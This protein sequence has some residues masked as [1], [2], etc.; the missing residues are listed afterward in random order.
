[1]V[2]VH[3][4]RVDFPHILAYMGVEAR[5]IQYIRKFALFYYNSCVKSKN[6]KNIMRKSTMQKIKDILD[7]PGTLGVGL[8][9]LEILFLGTIFLFNRQEKSSQSA[10]EGKML[11]DKYEASV[12][13]SDEFTDDMLVA[14]NAIK[15]FG[16]NK[17]SKADKDRFMR[18]KKEHEAKADAYMTSLTPRISI[19]RAIDED[20]LYYGM[21]I[22]EVIDMLGQPRKRQSN[23][24]GTYLYY[25]KYQLVFDSNGRYEH[26]NYN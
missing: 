11:V 18:L 16:I 3:T 9:I 17:L 15:V 19:Q 5:I 23:R 6:Q 25:G 21:P 13:G 14:C 20:R 10:I 12:R 1:M 22:S 7:L 2:N 26:Y 24:V 8:T 4:I